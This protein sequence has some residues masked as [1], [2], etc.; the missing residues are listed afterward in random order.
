MNSHG[1]EG[2]LSSA[3][4]AESNKFRDR[5]YKLIPFDF[6]KE[7][8]NK[9]YHRLSVL[10]KKIETDF[11]GFGYFRLVG[12]MGCDHMWMYLGIVPAFCFW[13]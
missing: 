12:A 13:H 1:S 10:W 11:K 8:G 2:M 5:G 9:N 3:F 7:C 4:I 6:H